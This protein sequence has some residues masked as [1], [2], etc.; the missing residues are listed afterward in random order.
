VNWTILE[1]LKWTEQHFKE[2]D[3]PNPRLDAEYLLADTLNLKRVDL[4]VKFDQLIT[5]NERDTFKELIRRRVKHEPLQHILGTQ[6]F[7]G[8]T[9][10]VSS[11]VLIPRQETELLVEKGALL[12]ENMESPRILDVGTGSGCIAISMAKSFPNAQVFATDISPRALDIAH[13]NAKL[14]DTY[15]IEFIECDLFPSESNFDLIIS[16]PPYIPESEMTTLQPEVKNYDPHLALIGGSDGLDFYRRI[17]NQAPTL[18]S[19]SG[20]LL[21]EFGENQ[22]GSLKELAATTKELVWLDSK[23]DYN[24]VERIATTQKRCHHG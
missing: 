10:K 18:L 23:K 17:F 22:V 12:L 4:Y 14:N 21:V 13:A 24:G 15:N 9:F 16:N 2:H 8:F 19:D 7:Y 6:E 5:Q 20:Y 1:L 11:D 3:I